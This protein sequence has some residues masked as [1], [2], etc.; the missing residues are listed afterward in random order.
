[1]T[2]STTRDQGMSFRR[3]ALLALGGALIAQAAWTTWRIATIGFSFADLWRPLAFSAAFLLVVVTRGNVR[4]FNA[5]GRVTIAMAFLLA[6]WSRFGNFPGFIRYAESVLSF[7][8]TS[9]IPLLAVAATICEVSLCVAMLIGFKTRWASAAS[10]VLLL[11]F[12]TSMVASGLSQFEWAVYVLAAGAFVLATADAT[13][14]GVDAILLRKERP[15]TSP[16]A[17]H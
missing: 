8:P 15:R 10:A 11:M 14:F 7:M 6:L 3:F 4:P 9:S 17:T 12:A 16:V 5:L 1:M 2:I 13:L